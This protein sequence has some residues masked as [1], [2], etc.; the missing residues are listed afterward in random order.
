MT[1]EEKII[2]AI[3]TALSKNIIL[4]P[5]PAAFN[6]A[7]MIGR[8]PISCSGIGALILFYNLEKDGNFTTDWHKKLCKLMDTTPW[9]LWRFHIGFDIG[10]SVL[11][12]VDPGKRGA[13]AKIFAVSPDGKRIPLIEDEISKMGLRLRRKYMGKGK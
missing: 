5:G 2:T 10:N 6:F 4:K 12:N 13:N 11:R 9:W 8:S 1:K 3:D 7:T